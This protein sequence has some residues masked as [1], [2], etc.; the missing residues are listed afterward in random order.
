MRL[1]LPSPKLD[2]YL[3]LSTQ[4][5]EQRYLGVHLYDA[6]LRDAV[7]TADF[8]QR[9]GKTD[10]RDSLG[11]VYRKTAGWDA[12]SRML[13]L[14]TKTW[15]P[16]DILIKADRMSMATS[17]ELREPFLD[18][19]LVEFA[20]TIPSRFKIRNGRTK[21]ILKHALRG[22]LPREILHRPKMGFPTPLAW[23]FRGDLYTYVRDVLLDSR[24][25]SR[26][27]FDSRVVGQ[28]VDEHLAGKADHHSALWRLLIL[29]EW[30]RQFADSPRRVV[31][32]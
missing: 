30:H 17:I 31:A 20:A 12:L 27:Y 26:G 5:L 7:Y 9:L 18:Y 13:Y 3:H 23:M 14:D 10:P 15:L 28:F 16:N 4:P 19:R 29:E 6:R 25:R 11:A 22:V 2:K 24:T 32:A 21:H 1:A 8:R